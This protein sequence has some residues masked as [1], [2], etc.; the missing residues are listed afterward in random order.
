M[1]IIFLYSL[2]K[3]HVKFYVIELNGGGGEGLPLFVCR[4]ATVV[5]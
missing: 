4:S 3:M 1:S 5:V 2:C